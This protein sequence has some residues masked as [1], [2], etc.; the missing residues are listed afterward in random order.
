VYFTFEPFENY[1][2]ASKLIRL[3]FAHKVPMVNSV[4]VVVSEHPTIVHLADQM[5]DVCQIVFRDFSVRRLPYF[6]PDLGTMTIQ[7]VRFVHNLFDGR[8]FASPHLMLS[9]AGTLLLLCWHSA[10]IMPQVGLQMPFL[11]V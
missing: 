6:F 4:A 10:A 7:L 11:P 8:L 5:I 1:G 3:H 2:V 9:F